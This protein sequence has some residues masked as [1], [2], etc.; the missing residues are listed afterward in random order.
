M[1]CGV[2]TTAEPA[3]KKPAITADE[4]IV[5][6]IAKQENKSSGRGRGGKK[7]GRGGHK[8]AGD[9][10]KEDEAAS[11]AAN[12]E[13]SKEM[14][15]SIAPPMQPKTSGASKITRDPEI[16]GTHEITVP[17]EMT[18]TSEITGASEMTGTSGVLATTPSQS[19]NSEDNSSE[20]E[21]PSETENIIKDSDE[22]DED[23]AENKDGDSDG[24][25]DG[26]HNSDD[27]VD[28]DEDDNDVEGER[29]EMAIDKNN[30]LT[31]IEEED[32]DTMNIDSA[33]VSDVVPTKQDLKGA[34]RTIGG[35][36]WG[37]AQENNFRFADNINESSPMVV[38]L[39][40]F[41]YITISDE[42]PKFNP[43][44]LN[45][46]TPLQAVP[47]LISV[48]KPVGF[49]LARSVGSSFGASI[50]SK[51]SEKAS[52]SASA[53][54]EDNLDIPDG[55]TKKQE[56]IV[57]IYKVDESLLGHKNWSI[58][59][60]WKIYQEPLMK[61]LHKMFGAAGTAWYYWDKAL[62]PISNYPDMEEW[63]S[64]ADPPDNKE[65]CK[66][67]GLEKIAELTRV[68]LEN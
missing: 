16:T 66:L 8:T 60:A 54:T 40:G 24:D 42:S 22:E 28:D 10:D 37:Q 68:D 58:H 3:A 43:T 18:G 14:S 26:D 31:Q 13:K 63:L 49:H 4:E 51:S 29:E 20:L 62:K 55:L 41:V 15:I 11:S 32:M 57:S 35:I 65:T 50:T 12:K 9:K 45:I 23:D 34:S 44:L 21:H 48:K 46:E 33:L 52:A 53:A 1:T 67:W 56:L 38:D 59:M 17:S 7:R 25:G 19:S 61:D 5:D 36:F 30:S 64:S 6:N 47:T 39:Q 27:N 2:D